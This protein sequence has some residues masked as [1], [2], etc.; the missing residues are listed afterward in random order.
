[1]A[2]VFTSDLHHL[3]SRRIDHRNQ[4]RGVVRSLWI[5]VKLFLLGC[6]FD[7]EGNETVVAL[8]VLKYVKDGK[9][10][11]RLRDKV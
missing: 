5:T 6:W 8:D 7:E 1:M 11:V 9:R 3:E 4:M 2:I 10:C